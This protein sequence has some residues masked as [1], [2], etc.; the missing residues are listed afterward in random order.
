[1]VLVFN[2]DIVVVTV[3]CTVEKDP[4]ELWKL[5]GVEK[6]HVVLVFILIEVMVLSSKEPEDRDNSNIGI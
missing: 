3:G 2:R 6:N 1:M 4:W 5:F